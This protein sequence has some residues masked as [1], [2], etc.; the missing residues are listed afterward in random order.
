MDEL[1]VYALG[2]TDHAVARS[3]E[4]AREIF[5]GHYGV[6]AWQLG[7]DEV[8]ELGDYDRLVIWVDPEDRPAE[9]HS[10][11]ARLVDLST[12]EWCVRAGRPGWLCTTEY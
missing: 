11:G 4:E 3:L 2:D 1:K 10:D 5:A 7:P 6:G 12:T 9:P 8:R